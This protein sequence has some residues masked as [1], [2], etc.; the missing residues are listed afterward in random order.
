MTFPG[1]EFKWPVTVFREIPAPAARVWEV[2]SRP[3]NLELC[4]PFCEKNPV[5]KWPGPGSRDKIHYLS[6]WVMQRHFVKWIEG[7]GYD[8]EIGRQGG[9]QSF[10]SWRIKSIQENRSLLSISVYPHILQNLP[11][12]IR[13]KPYL[14]YIKPQ[15]KRYLLSVTSGFEWYIIHN[16]PVPRNHFGYHP[17]FSPEK[18]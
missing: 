2:I 12:L 7:I 8:L 9:S 1:T 17:W 10:V 13:W 4:H 18:K 11:V 14:F 16:E 5:I 6:G 15:L 3:G